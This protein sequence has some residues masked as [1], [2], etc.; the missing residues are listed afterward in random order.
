VLV[1]GDEK[2]VWLFRDESR[3]EAL[4]SLS[5][6]ASDPELS[7]TWYDAVC[8]SKEIRGAVSE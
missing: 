3:L 4:R 7:L 2:Y 1:K 8:M 6:F 5:R